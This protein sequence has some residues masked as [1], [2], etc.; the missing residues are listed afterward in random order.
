MCCVCQ[1]CLMVIV[2]VSL[3]MCTQ[4]CKW[5]SGKESFGQRWSAGDVVGCVLDMDQGQIAFTLNG[6]LLQDS[7]GSSVAFEGVRGVALMPTVT[8][9]AGQRA[10]LNFGRSEVY[11]VHSLTVCVWLCVYSCVWW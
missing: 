4:A 9:A 10:R 7:L 6:D 3:Y 2:V 11:T 8:L 1:M 5:H